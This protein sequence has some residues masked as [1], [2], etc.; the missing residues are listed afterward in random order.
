MSLGHTSSV[1]PMDLKQHGLK[2][3]EYVPGHIVDQYLHELAEHFGLY[4]HILLRTNVVSAILLQDGGWQVIFN[5]FFI[6]ESAQPSVHDDF[7]DKMALATGLTSEP[8]DKWKSL[9]DS[10]VL[11]YLQTLN[12]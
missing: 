7:A 10:I 2:V 1:F 4:Q 12:L 8:Q 3:G 11:Q 9:F 6:S 5:S